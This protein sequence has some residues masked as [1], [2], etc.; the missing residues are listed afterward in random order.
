MQRRSGLPFRGRKSRKAQGRAQVPHTL[1]TTP[2]DLSHPLPGK[3][4]HLNRRIGRRPNV[5]SRGKRLAWFNRVWDAFGYKRNKAEAA[6]AFIDIEGH[7]RVPGG[8]HMP[9]GGTGS[10]AQARPCGA[11]QNAEDADGLA[12][13]AAMGG[14]GGRTAPAC[15]GC[16]PWTLCSAIPSSTCRRRRS[17]RKAGRRACRSWRNGGMARGRI[18]PDSLTAG[19]RCPFRRTLGASCNGRC[20]RIYE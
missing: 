13:R 14:R 20:R 8:R 17:A 3:G 4:P 15:A 16:G 11:G 1:R 10:G 18:R 6:D 5:S 19:S 12:V 9:G 2:P 7:V